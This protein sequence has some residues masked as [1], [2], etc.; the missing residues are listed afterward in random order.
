MRLALLLALAVTIPATTGAVTPASAATHCTATFD[1]RANHD[2]GTVATGSMLRGA[3]DFRSAESVW[4]EN[5]TLSHLSE[6]TMAI[7][8]ED[9]SS[10]DGKISVVHVVRTPE[11]A[12]YVSF[13]AGHVHGDLGGIT[14]YEDPM[15]VTLYGPPA[16]LDSPELPLSEAD[17]NS[18]NKRMVFQV[19]TP[20]TMRTFSGVIEEWRGSCRAE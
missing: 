19:H 8:A 6:G 2:H 20:D 15:L 12:D 1:I 18:L 5:K 4:S 7:T 16:T 10:V 17:W 11:I 3:I 14:A 13:D 9:G